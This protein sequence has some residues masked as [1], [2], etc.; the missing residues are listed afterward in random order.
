[1]KTFG[2]ITEYNSQL[3]LSIILIVI[4]LVLITL[5]LGF[6]A[7]GYEYNSIYEES[8]PISTT[9]F[10][11]AGILLFAI[12]LAT[13]FDRKEQNIKSCVSNNIQTAIKDNYNNV[14][15][16]N[17]DIKT[18]GYFTSNDTTYGYK[19]SNNVLVITEN[20]VEVNYISGEKY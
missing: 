7:K 14:Q 1:M 2:T 12:G 3:T 10:I 17:K 19:I 13:V 20:G 8:H 18:E 4:G 9:I 5:V 15:F 16:L 11:M 6:I